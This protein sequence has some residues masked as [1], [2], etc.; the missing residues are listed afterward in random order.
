MSNTQLN[1]I[2]K[3]L[4]QQLRQKR[5]QLTPNQQKNAAKKTAQRLVKL[6]CFKTAQR[7]AFYQATDGELNPQAL[8]K[9]A[10]KHHKKCYLPVLRRFPKY[11]LAFVRIYAHSRLHK[12]RF[13]FKEPQGRPRLFIH[14]LDMVCMPLVGFDSHCQRLGMGGGF[15]DRSLARKKWGQAFTVGLAHQCQQVT[16]IPIAAWDMALNAV[17]TPNQSHLR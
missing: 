3:Q 12:H 4:R 1:L 7:I 16:Q 6:P 8:I 13:G 17:L 5:R 14:Q 15:Y 11:E 10:L 9:L 2:R